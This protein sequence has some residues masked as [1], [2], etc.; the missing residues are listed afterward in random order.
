MQYVM[1]F[2]FEDDIMFAHN[3]TDQDDA[4]TAYIYSKRL[5]RANLTST[6]AL[7]DVSVIKLS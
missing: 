5:I 7:Y 2:R 1:Y 3:Q 6:V 4:N